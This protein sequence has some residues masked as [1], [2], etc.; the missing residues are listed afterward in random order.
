MKKTMSWLFVALA[1][2]AF[3]FGQDVRIQDQAAITYAG[4]ECTGSYSQISA[5][6]GEFMGTFFGQGLM[7]TG[8]VFS[9]YFNS[10]G[11]GVSEADLKWVIGMPISPAASPA[12]PLVKGE[13]NYPK[14]A[15]CLHVGPY[16]KVGETYG[17]IMAF[18][19]QNGWKPAGPAM[20]SYLNNP[21]VVAPD[22]LRTEIVIPVEKK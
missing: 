17:K 7:P 19:D 3:G 8:G 18:I 20:E 5:K 9:L 10:P 14:V 16:E 6:I 11:P 22:K 2:A 15:Y 13:F 1:C 12:A 4:L 21:Q